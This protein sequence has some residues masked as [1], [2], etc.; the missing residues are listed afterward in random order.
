MALASSPWPPA[1]KVIWK[2][3]WI[4]VSRLPPVSRALFASARTWNRSGSDRREVRMSTSIA[5]HPPMAASSNS[6]GV[7]S[8]PLLVPNVSWP[9]RVLVAVKTPGATRSTVTVRC[10]ESLAIPLPCQAHGWSAA[11]IWPLG[12]RFYPYAG[13]RPQ[14]WMS[15]L[16]MTTVAGWLRW[17]RSEVQW[18]SSSASEITPEL[19]AFPHRLDERQQMRAP[20]LSRLRQSRVDAHLHV[21]D[22]RLAQQPCQAPSHE[23]VTAARA[24]RLVEHL[25]Q[26]GPRLVMRLTHPGDVIDVLQHDDTTRSSERHHLPHQFAAFR[27]VDQHQPFV[28]QIERVA[29]QARRQGVT[30]DDRH[31]SQAALRDLGARHLDEPALALKADDLTIAADQ[32]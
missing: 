15:S 16:S 10:T 21:Q 19:I 11:W 6:V 8:V 28:D 20:V 18:R 9:P 31:V 25:K 5:V 29:F 32:L 27:N 24:E 1:G 13:F 26:D 7:N 3:T 30:L 22:A 23:R 14:L 12:G 4:S 17:P 2:T